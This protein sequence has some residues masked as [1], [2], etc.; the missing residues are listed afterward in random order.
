MEL[1]KV[2]TS[3]EDERG[4]ITDIL[5]NELIDHI[6]AIY[7]KKGAIRGN[8]FHKDTLQGIFVLSGQMKLTTQIPN[9][10]IQSTILVEGDLAIT[11]PWESHAFKAIEDT[12]FMVFTRGPRAGKDYEKDTFRLDVPLIE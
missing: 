9:E 11:P 1:R 4:T 2:R 6:T 10:P 12:Y 7:S 3:Y 5:S 8:H